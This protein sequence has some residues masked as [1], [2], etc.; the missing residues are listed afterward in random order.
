MQ[1]SA[2][3][4]SCLIAG[5]LFWSSFAGDEAGTDENPGWAHRR[6]AGSHRDRAGL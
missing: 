6:Q 4:C 3:V 5:K 2:F 1:L